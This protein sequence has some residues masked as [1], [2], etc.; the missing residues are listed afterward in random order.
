MVDEGRC[1][2]SRHIR[3]ATWRPDD[4]GTL[5]DLAQKRIAIYAD[6]ALTPRGCSS[7]WSRQRATQPVGATFTVIRLPHWGQ[8]RGGSS[9]RPQPA[10]SAVGRPQP[11]QNPLAI[12]V[13]VL[14]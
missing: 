1:Q 9:A 8:N 6:A 10:Q 5:T 12:Y 13:D 14:G 11:E 3:G 2:W 7:P 4:V